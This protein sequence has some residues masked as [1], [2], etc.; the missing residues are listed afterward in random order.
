MLD[1]I[2]ELLENED[3][4]AALERLHEA[5]PSP[6]RDASLRLLLEHV[7]AVVTPT[8]PERW[9]LACVE[10]GPQAAGDWAERLDE[11]AL[12]YDGAGAPALDRGCDPYCGDTVE[13]VWVLARR[14]ERAPWAEAI[15]SL[16]C[17]WT[18]GDLAEGAVI[19][20]VASGVGQ[21]VALLRAPTDPDAPS[22]WW[23]VEWALA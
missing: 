17:T 21:V 7:E 4:F 22:G 14:E 1:A 23:R 18:D 6:E 8:S 9:F 16:G 11:V 13:R 19:A 10:P 12:R 3:T 15:A 2:R 5:A 20:D